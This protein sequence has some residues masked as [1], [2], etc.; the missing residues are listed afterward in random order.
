MLTMREGGEVFFAAG[1]PWYVALFG[2]DSIIT[3]LETLAYQPA[4][5]ANT[6]ELLAKYQGREVDEWR[7]EQP[8]KILH[9]LRVGEKANLEEVPQTPYYGTVDATPLFIILLAE[10][11]RW[12]ADIGLWRRLRSNV[13]A[14]LRWIDD[15]GDSDGDGF[16]DYKSTSHKGMDNQGWKDSG[17][18]VRNRDGSLAVPPIALVEVQSYVYRARLEAAWLYRRD[19]NDDRAEQLERSA[20]SLRQAFREAY[21]M[22]D[23]GT[24]AE[25]IQSGGR[26]AD[27]LTSNPG[28][29]LWGGIVDQDHAEAVARMLCH[30]SMN[31]GWGIRT[32][33]RGEAAYNPIDYQ[34]GSIWPHDNAMIC[35][36]LKRYRFNQ[37]ALQVFAGIYNAA[38]LFPLY[39]LPEVF[40]GFASDQYPRPVRYPVACSPQAWAAGAL[41]YLLQSVLGLSP[42]ALEGE[43]HIVNPTLPDFLGEVTLRGLRLGNGSIDLRYQRS[44]DA[45]LVAVLHRSGDVS[46][47]IQY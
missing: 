10:Y 1:V 6:L 16:I 5:A 19:G 9:E 20:H 39:R 43:L 7:E 3:A 28:Q 18:S 12:T 14:A 36:G 8:G 32:L 33:A 47:K 42:R 13:D 4:I 30:S 15:Y 38:T 27:A 26:Q 35:A 44:G 34:V 23:R 11:I 17:N 24:L 29:A 21:W 22:E 45:T 25:A 31:S 37:Q 41:P 2:R 46:V 40:A